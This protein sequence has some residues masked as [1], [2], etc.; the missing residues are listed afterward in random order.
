MG[1]L[2]KVKG[3][4]GG[5]GLWPQW[6]VNLSGLPSDLIG[7]SLDAFP[8]SLGGTLVN[9]PKI[10][11]MI[12]SL[13]RNPVAHYPLLKFVKFPNLSNLTEG[14]FLSNIINEYE[15]TPLEYS[16]GL[17]FYTYAILICWI[18]FSEF[19]LLEY[20]Y[21]KIYSRCFNHIQDSV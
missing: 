11:S 9:L 17:H 16:Q 4:A 15:H 21:P 2:Q 10:K 1:V 6:E 3:R 12:R 14:K 5:S 13:L 20:S 8:S 7:G 19:I 18:I